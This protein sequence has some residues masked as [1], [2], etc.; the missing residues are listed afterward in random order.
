MIY[1]VAMNRIYH[2][3]PDFIIAII[4]PGH[5]R[6]VR[7]SLIGLTFLG[8]LILSG[9]GG[10]S[11]A[12]DPPLSS[13][14]PPPPAQ[15]TVEGAPEDA[16]IAVNWSAVVGASSYNIYYSTSPGVTKSNG[17]KVSGYASPLT[18]YDLT[19]GTRYYAVVTSVSPG[20]ESA[21]S[22]EKS[23]VPADTDEDAPPPAPLNPRADAGNGQ[24]VYS[25]DASPGASSYNLY[26]ATASGVTATSGG[27]KV[28]GVTRPY[29]LTPLTSSTTYYAVITAVGL[30]SGAPL[31]GSESFEVAA[32]PSTVPPPLAPVNL[33][34]ALDI[35]D[36][37]TVVLNWS[38]SAGATKYSLYYGPAWGVTQQTGTLIDNVTSPYKISGL[39][40]NSASFFVLTASNGSGQSSDSAQVA[41]TP[42]TTALP[43]ISQ[44]MVQIPAG[45]FQ[46]G[47]NLDS[48][49]YAKP[50]TMVAVSPFYIDK[51]ETGYDAWVPVYNWA[52]NNGYSFD[53]PGNNGSDSP[54][55]GTDLPVTLI[56]WYDVLKWMNAR[57]EMEG[58]TPAYYTNAGKT[59]IY[60]SGDVDISNAMVNWAGCGYRLPTE[61]EWEKADRGGLTGERY[62]WG[63]DPLD[64]NLV[65][66]SLANYNMGRTT[67][68]GVYPANGFGLYDMAGNVWEWTWNW[69]T[70]D[71]SGLSLSDPHGVDVNPLPG[72]ADFLRVRR[73]GGYAYGPAYLRS[74]ER[75][76]R[77]PSYTGPYF[78]FRAARSCA[79]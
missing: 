22:K 24:I 38:P 59:Q 67:S 63:N 5:G 58:K 65:D 62:P 1:S 39:T 61:A 29:T 32:T 44:R 14:P 31:E 43:P 15:L 73:G 13:E 54:E 60:R 33:Q 8:S 37:G 6:F 40:K 69:W 34:S 10:G 49:S 71:Y 17:T 47:D 2:L 35:T 52:I 7:L 77:P 19:P 30:S 28:T 12:A 9:C 72:A 45:S 56:S 51:F 78:G 41:A 57:S 68:M 27:T 74:A 46:M 64:Y 20:G 21:V 76:P 70:A 4:K 23:A 55:L 3:I 66:P 36:P 50:A 42:R 26:Y 53:N 48:I 79:P 18:I 11:V 25:W 16:R 75:V